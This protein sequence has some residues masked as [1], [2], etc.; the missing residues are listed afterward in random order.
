MRAT[1]NPKIDRPV[2]RTGFSQQ[3]FK[4]FREEWER[5]TIASN[6]M[7]ENL[8][9]DML[10]Q[11]ADLS[12]Q[13]LLRDTIRST[14]MT[15]MSVVGLMT[16]LE[17]ETS[18]GV[19]PELYETRGNVTTK[20]GN[21]TFV[22]K[23]VWRRKERTRYSRKRLDTSGQQQQSEEDSDTQALCEEIVLLSISLIS[24]GERA[25]RTQSLE[26]AAILLSPRAR[27]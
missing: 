26:T 24:G 25:P 20:K 5:Y 11:C 18:G 2:I 12:L 1:M 21:H 7:K 22:W 6:I 23:D 27:P 17:K 9:R 8:L 3:D 15:N 19:N 16:E 10:L 13:K 4:F 14:T